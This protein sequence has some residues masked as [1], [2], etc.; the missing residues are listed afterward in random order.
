MLAII[1]KSNN[2]EGAMKSRFLREYTFSDIVENNLETLKG[3]LM[4]A[5]SLVVVNMFDFCLAFTFFHFLVEW[6][7]SGNVVIRTMCLHVW[8]PLV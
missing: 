8:A 7:R 1:N 4:M 2:C 3:S 5:F 6:I